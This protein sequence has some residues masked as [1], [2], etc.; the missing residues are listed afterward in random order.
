MA[1]KELGLIPQTIIT[2]GP[3]SEITPDFCVQGKYAGTSGYPGTSESQC[4]IITETVSVL[5]QACFSSPYMSI[6]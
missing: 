4:S 6:L 2:L 1:K 5:N 3:S